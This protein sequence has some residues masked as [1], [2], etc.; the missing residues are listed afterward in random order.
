M[1]QQD[2]HGDVA[3]RAVVEI[4]KRVKKAFMTNHP[5]TAIL[6]IRPHIEF[7]D[8][9]PVEERTKALA[10]IGA[11]VARSV[12]RSLSEGVPMIGNGIERIIKMDFDPCESDPMRSTTSSGYLDIV[13]A[14]AIK[15]LIRKMNADLAGGMRDEDACPGVLKMTVHYFLSQPIE[16]MHIEGQ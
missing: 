16:Y 7:D 5:V 13:K 15:G 6:E 10:G 14:A 9:L 2:S 11:N 8:A 12:V 1:S 3:A 4:R